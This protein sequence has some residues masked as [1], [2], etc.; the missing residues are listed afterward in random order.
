M[1]AFPAQ[2][3]SDLDLAR[4]ARYVSGLP[5]SFVPPPAFVITVQILD[6]DPWFSPAQVTVQPW[7]TVRF[8]NAGS[9]YH[10]VVELDWMMSSGRKGVNSGPLGPGGE[11]YLR[12][13]TPGLKTILC[14]VHPYMRGEIHVSQS[15][16]PPSYS[17]STPAPVPPIPGVGEIWV[18]A[19][20]QDW[21]G[22]TKDGV[23]QVIDAATWS[24]SHMI[25]VGNN[26]HNIWFGAG[27]HEALV[28]NWFDST[29]SRI[30][31]LTK[32]VTSSACVAG[33]AP[34]H[35]TSDY[36][37][38]YWF[39]SIEGSN[40]VH[41]FTQAGGPWGLCVASGGNPQAAWLSG[42]GPHGIWY[43]SGKLVTANSMDSTLSIISAAS[44]QETAILP[45]GMMPMGA[46]ASRN[47]EFA[48]SG[49]AM[50]MSVSIYDLVQERYIRDIP[51]GSSVI[52]VPFTPD[53]R[54]I[55][56]A[57]GSGITIID[58]LKAADPVAFPNPTAAIVASIW[59]GNGAHG[60]AFG[61]KLGGGLYAYVTHKFENYVSVIDLGALQKAG[62]VPLTTTTTGK[63]SLAGATDTG[64][65]GL[66][67]WPN[68]A[69]WQ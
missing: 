3:I 35:V 39:L 63:I 32:T 21:P 56:A 23:V 46:S 25:P 50:G 28:T 53:S 49:N 17:V 60:V 4:L 8:V 26:P 67:V 36:S 13:A 22:K 1:P 12:F 14:G 62:D 43:S 69:P 61:R 27:S 31:T 64:G 44:L 55:V 42:Y 58:A 24:V 20:F 57:G 47:G 54:F 68:P 48:A 66:A 5:N 41:R 40:Y 29:V 37:G 18:C 38:T 33:A 6:E 52:Q 15:F 34:A 19:Q 65:N 10:P 16:T 2:A 51:V 30:S 59:T 7:E 45:S 11:F 9:T